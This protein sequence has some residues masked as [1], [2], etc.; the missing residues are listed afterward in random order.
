MNFCEVDIADYNFRD[1]GVDF[2][3]IVGLGLIEINQNPTYANLED[4][5]FWTGVISASSK[6]YFALR[7]TRGEY[8]GGE[9]VEEEDLIGTRVTGAVH[10]ASIDTKG[11]I[12]NW[13]YWNIIQKGL[14]K[15]CLVSSAGLLYY[16]DKPCSI[17]TKVNNQRNQKVQAYYQS[18]IKWYDLSNPVILNAPEGIFYGIEPLPFDRIFDFTFDYTFS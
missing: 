16:V 4:P 7:N 2:A 8:N 17:Y 6:K 12:E 14:W 11:I 13:E 10:I 9:S 15:V 5:E 3:G 18:E 1:C